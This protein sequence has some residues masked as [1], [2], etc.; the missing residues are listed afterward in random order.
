MPSGQRDISGSVKALRPFVPA[1]NFALSKK[2][3]ADLGFR[4]TLLGDKLAEMRLGDHSFL[5]QD[6]YVEE[7]AGNFV[8]HVLVDD[9]KGW[10]DRIVS[11]DLA[12]RYGVKSPIPPKLESWGLTVVYVFDPSGVLWHFAETPKKKR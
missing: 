4:M 1:K 9:L 12:S 6:Y 11:L 8:M 10:W 3:Y 7:W 5:L 2:F